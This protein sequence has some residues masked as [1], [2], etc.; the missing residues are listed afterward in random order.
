MSAVRPQDG[1]QP[2]ASDLQQLQA[3]AMSALRQGRFDIVDELLARGDVSLRE[4]THN[5]RVY[6]AELEA[7]A[8]ELRDSQLRTERIAQQFRRL[9][10]ALPQPAMVVDRLGMV[11]RCNSQAERLFGLSGEAAVKPA[12]RRIGADGSVRH[13]LHGALAEAGLAGQSQLRSVALTYCDGV[14]RRGDVYVERLDDFDGEQGPLL[15]VLVIDESERMAAADALAQSN[16]ALRQHQRENRSLATVAR[17]T[18][19]M[20]LMTDPQ[21]RI[22]WANEAMLTLSGYT[23]NEL[24]G[25]T[26]K[27][28]QGSGTDPAT[29]AL[30]REHLNRGVGFTGV[31]VLNYSK[32]GQPYWIV[33]DVQPVA[34]DDG[35]LEGFISVQIDITERLRADALMRESEAYQRAIFDATPAL[36]AVLQRDGGISNVNA[37]GLAMLQLPDVART[38][39]RPLAGFLAPTDTERFNEAL[40]S[41]MLGEESTATVDLL[42]CEGRVCTVELHTGPLWRL[43]SVQYVVA[44]GRDI[45]AER[46]V[47]ALRA[48]KEAAEAAS[49]AKSRFLSQMSHEL[50]TPLN[51][52]LGFTQLMLADLT[53]GA[54]RAETQRSRLAII[55]QAGWHLLSMIDDVLDLSRIESGRI[56]MHLDAVPVAQAL[57]D[58]LVLVQGAVERRHIELRSGCS[59]AGV[60]V[61]ADPVR[62]KQVLSNLL[63]NAVKYNVDGGRVELQAQG[64]GD[65]VLISVH[66]TGRGLQPQQI[67]HLFEPFNRLGAPSS[68][69]GSGIGLVIVRHLVQLMGGTIDVASVPGESATFM[70]R[71]PQPLTPGAAPSAAAHDAPAAQPAR[72]RRVLYIEDVESNIELM[73]QALAGSRWT[74]L[75]ERSGRNGL[76]AARRLLPDLILLDLQLPDVDGVEVRRHLLADRAT[77]AIPCVAVTADGAA[78][79]AQGLGVPFDGWLDKPLRIAMMQRV[80]SQVAGAG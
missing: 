41:A 46:A 63:S 62:L 14:L 78:R 36:V 64:E 31:E 38:L 42:G 29:V 12:L 71:L 39:G 21:L 49:Q 19:S 56:D 5:L 53:S 55:E 66:N 58:A 72:Q 52:V 44:I 28:F 54:S 30:M 4:L 8:L 25:R 74:L 43:G 47:G 60:S 61:L 24:E 11:Q 33:L 27:L 70:V 79:N 37:A 73:H 3:E 15:L 16:L 20:V 65:S 9:F 51:A 22:T 32:A 50:R 67:E 17:A 26:P 68:I 76:E 34:G 75:V 23:L 48:D 6:Q 35:R 10:D 2:T 57:N 59:P 13:A 7:Q 77:A 80:M 18:H 69:E 40:A 45:S 1:G